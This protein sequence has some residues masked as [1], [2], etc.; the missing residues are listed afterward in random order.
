MSGHSTGTV[1]SLPR[2]GPLRIVI[3]DDHPIVRKGLTELVNGAP[4]MT[5]CGESDTAAGGFDRI[6]LTQ[7]DVA[8]VDLSLGPDSG[9]RLVEQVAASLPAVRVLVLSMYDETLHAERSLA[10][11]ARG[12]IMKQEA[13]HELLGA[14]RR[15][16]SGKTY[17]SPGMAER[18]VTRVTHRGARD[19]TRAP[20][21]R[22]TGREL[23]VF[24]M[25]GRGLTTRDMAQKLG[26]SVKTV[27]TYQTRIKEKLGL[28]N[29]H[30]LMRAAMTWVEP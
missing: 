15:V 25:V 22:L 23:E 9:L 26:I 8:I 20:I 10:A 12:Y 1:P 13:M 21:E 27:E 17:V 14:I 30:E 5:L 28:S 18:I 2:S 7:P 4:D 6:R 16:A 11:G 29:G 3:V 19:D 24:T